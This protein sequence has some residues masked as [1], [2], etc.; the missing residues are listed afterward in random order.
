MIVQSCFDRMTAYFRTV[1]EWDPARVAERREPFWTLK[2]TAHG[3]TR[4]ENSTAAH[5][6]ALA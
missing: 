5:P 4:S 6:S 1:L 2:S 3:E